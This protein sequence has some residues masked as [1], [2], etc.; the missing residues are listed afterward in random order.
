MPIKRD[1]N[2]SYEVK[3]YQFQGFVENDGKIEDFSFLDLSEVNGQVIKQKDEK[4]ERIIRQEREHAKTTSFKISDEVKQYRGISRQEESDFEQ[5]VEQEVQRRLE[6][7]V[8]EA[9]NAGRE[10]GLNEGK[11]L[12][13]NEAS[14]IVNEKIIELAS[15]IEE[16]QSQTQNILEKN[17]EDMYKMIRS[18]VKWVVFKEVGD[19][20]YLPS[21]LEKLI[22]ELNQKN[23]LIIRVNP[24][25]INVMPSVL[26][27]VQAKL[28][29]LKNV[30]VEIDRDMES[31]GIVLEGENGIIDGSL[32]SQIASINAVFESAGLLDE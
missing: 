3:E 12:A 29:E 25:S 19:D 1:E 9:R 10:S 31:K 22:H 6:L 18:M 32:E 30:R 2:S 15:I 23:N 5:R 26:E 4:H 28:G 14:A 17:K 20:S 27:Q 13:Y 16:L 11:E 8:E 21:L 24:D 7:A